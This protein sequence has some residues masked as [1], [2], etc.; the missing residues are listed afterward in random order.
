MA[1][2]EPS[3][4]LKKS[5]VQHHSSDQPS[6][7]HSP[8]IFQPFRALGYVTNELPFSL[9]VRGK[10]YFLTTCIGNTFQIYDCVKLNLLFVG[11]RTE[12]PITAIAASG[13]YTFA[14]CNKNIIVYERAK[15][16]RRILGDGGD[17]FSLTI[18]SNYLIASRDDNSI[19]IWDFTTAEKV[20][21]IKLDP[22]FQ[23]AVL[24]HP[25]TYL[26]KI[27]VGSTNGVMQIWNF[28]TKKLVYTFS[29]FSSPIT[30]L[31]QSPVVDVIAVGLLD[32][33]IIIYN[34]KADEQVLSF[35]QEGTV[36]SISFRTDDQHVMASANMSGDITLWDLDKRKLHHLMKGA[37][38]GMIPSIQFF[39]GQPI[40]ITSGTDN[41]IKEWIFD[42]ADGV[43]RLL[44][45]RSGH[46]LPPTTIQYYGQDGQWILSGAGDR[47]LRAF[48]VIRD[49]QSVEL[50]QGSVAKKSKHLNLK[51][52]ELKLPPITQ[53][54]ASEAKQKEWDNIL[55]CHL[56]DNGAR[57]WSFQNKVIGKHVLKTGDGT[58]VKSV[59][60]SACGNFGFVGSLGG[61]I[62]LYNMQS[63]LHRKS[64][65]GTDR[66]TKA[67]TGI[68]SDSLN[69]IIISS[70]LDGT[71]KL[72][73]FHTSKVLHTINVDSPIIILQFRVESELLAIVSDDMCIR[74]IDI[75]TRKIV[76]EFWGHR[77][78]VTDISFSPDGRWI[79]SA[80]L[81]ATIRTWDLP[82]GHMIDVFEVENVTTSLTFSPTG[83]FLATTHV[84]NVGIF[85]WANRT[86]FAN[87][88]LRSVSDEEIRPVEL[89]TTSGID[90]DVEDNLF[91]IENGQMD[92]TFFETPDQLTDQMITMSKLPKTKWQ[93]LLNLETIKARNKPKEPP[94]APE[95]TP[96]F[97]PTLPGVD[98][99][100]VPVSK[101][102]NNE[103]KLKSDSR[104]LHLSD[105]RL[106]T[107][108]VK[109]MK[110]AY[111]TKD[112]GDFFD[113]VKTLN[114]ANIDFE[115]RSLSMEDD[116]ADLRM[117]L[118]AIQSRLKTKKDFELVQSYLNHFLKIHG[119]VVI[120]NF[121]VLGDP[122]RAILTEHKKE[123][124][125]IE[126][127]LHY[128]L[129]LLDFFRK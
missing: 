72:W 10:V 1:P 58:S 8:R 29:P 120:A 90:S 66:H 12:T 37:H 116:F 122:I 77:N 27:L 73:D 21:E 61:Q 71:V 109:K 30:T 124:H 121:S 39:N 69:R 35:K 63:G 9:Q 42:S 126:E 50:S 22:G 89:P 55:T 45:S 60:I 19:A 57:T 118:E 59:H 78:R 86:Q 84:D 38:D 56:N 85:L 6:H 28:R 24:I 31:A 127:L 25:S 114:P 115:L 33:S 16:I 53:C 7:A 110:V 103:E 98:H 46:H 80:S 108:F 125:R 87:I 4:S 128:N 101:E 3:A 51:I 97:L 52:E 26:N 34:I 32:G 47:S 54:A 43:P 36:T 41:A 82:S 70:S 102:T 99:K 94:K 117:F 18:L 92:S 123:W 14:A 5:K 105:I 44:R 74:V 65:A 2:D 91:V 106:E 17:I 62:D 81:D 49:S 88:T 104:V 95:K 129:C 64:F 93:N 112:Y 15:E 111:E 40:L 67:V 119:D 96:F 23:L 100:F 79:V 107:E 76:R 83:D 48:S 11:S 13:D 20:T 68:G 113:Y 75:E